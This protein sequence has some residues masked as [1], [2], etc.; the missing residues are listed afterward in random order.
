MEETRK[1]T[2]RA[3]KTTRLNF[4]FA[5]EAVASEKVETK[6]TVKVPEGAKVFLSG[7]ATNATGETRVYRTK[8]LKAGEAWENYIVR[9]SHVVNGQTLTKE[10]QISLNAGDDR[11][12]SFDFN[13]ASLA[14]AR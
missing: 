10:Q 2:V 14:D 11:E 7:N 1:V 9:V 13:D 6:L 4:D 12:L 5:T 3:G 8:A